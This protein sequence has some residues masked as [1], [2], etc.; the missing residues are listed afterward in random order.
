M[1]LTWDL[2]VDEAHLSP[3]DRNEFGSGEEEM[4]PRTRGE[5]LLSFDAA[6]QRVGVEFRDGGDTVGGVKR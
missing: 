5:I 3:G 2:A 1:R 4:A 6:S